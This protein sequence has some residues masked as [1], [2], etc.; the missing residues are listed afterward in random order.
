M[1]TLA[2]SAAADL[3]D[4]SAYAIKYLESS[5]KADIKKSSELAAR[6]SESTDRASAALFSIACEE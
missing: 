3:A 1:W 5:R 2:R 6:S 4:S